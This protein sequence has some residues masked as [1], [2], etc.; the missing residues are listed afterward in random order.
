VRLDGRSAVLWIGRWGGYLCWLCWSL[1]EGDTPESRMKLRALTVGKVERGRFAQVP[2][3]GHVVQL[4]LRSACAQ[5]EGR[6]A[7]VNLCW[8][9]AM[10]RSLQL[11]FVR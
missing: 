10:P 6:S 5:G 3:V 1:W 11:G 2:T 8:V 7:C 4:S 9:H